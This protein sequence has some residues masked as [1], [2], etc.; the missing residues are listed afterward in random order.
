MKKSLNLNNLAQDAPSLYATFHKKTGIKKD[1]RQPS[2]RFWP[3]SWKKTSFKSY[4]RLDQVSFPKPMLSLNISLKQTLIDRTSSRNF[5]KRKVPIEKLSTLL[6]YGAGQKTG[7]EA[8]GRFYPS[9]GGLYP[10]ELY[11][12]SLN[13]DL[14]KGLY[15]YSI[16]N[17]GLETLIEFSNFNYR[18][19]F[20][21]QSWIPKSA[22]M[23]VVTAVFHRTIDKYGD[24]GYRHILSEAGHIAQNLYLLSSALK[25]AC[26][27][28]GGYRENSLGK[29]LDIEGSE[30]SVV[31]VIAFGMP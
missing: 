31:Y 12:I 16:Q 22:F 2:P 24:R 10:L 30:E 11:I 1:I 27:S 3:E 13:T 19:Y 20:I 18:R 5:S 8:L 26:C 21:R 17:H 29:L 7:S 4:P 28:I 9:G 15:H 23:I 6:F 25:L 14:K